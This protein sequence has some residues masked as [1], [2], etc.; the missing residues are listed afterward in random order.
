M[1]VTM[2]GYCHQNVTIIASIV[3]NCNN[4]ND[5]YSDIVN[6]GCHPVSPSPNQTSF[7]TFFLNSLIHP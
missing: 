6:V 4:L 7:V 2:H 3:D 1:I 5:C